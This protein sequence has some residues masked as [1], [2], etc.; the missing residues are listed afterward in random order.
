MN[1]DVLINYIDTSQESQKK[2]RQKYPSRP[3]EAGE[4][5]IV[6]DIVKKFSDK[7]KLRPKVS[8]LNDRITYLALIVRRLRRA[9][10]KASKNTI[11]ETIQLRYIE[12]DIEAFFHIAYSL[13]NLIARLTPELVDETDKKGI[14]S[15][16]FYEQRKW[17]MKVENADKD[18]EFSKYLKKETD[19]FEDFHFHRKQLAH[20]HPLIT[21]RPIPELELYFNTEEKE[22]IMPNVKV[23]EFVNKTANGIVDFISFYNDHFGKES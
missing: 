19:W 21:Y 12:I 16:S 6:F 1:I 15:K 13:L 2:M 23:S 7:K 20:Y 10:S 17:F 9:L 11:L 8:Y 18:P 22:G 4:A 3:I 5:F 14:P